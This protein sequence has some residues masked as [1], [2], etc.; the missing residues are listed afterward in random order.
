VTEQVQDIVYSLFRWDDGEIEFEGGDLPSRE[1]IVLRMSTGDLLL[2]G[3]RRIEGWSRIRQGVGP[4]EQRY[5]LSRDATPLLAGLSLQKHELALVAAF[6]GPAA[7]E[8]ICAALRQ[9]D[10][11]TCRALVGLWSVGVL[12]RVPQ[13]LDQPPPR[14]KTEPHAERSPGASIGREVELFN[15]L[16]CFLFDLVTFELRDR[17]SA[18]FLR[19]LTRAREDFPALFDGASI[20]SSG[21]VD[22]VQLRQNVVGHEIAGYLRGLD[23]LLV[24]EQDMARGALGERKAAIIA[25]G[26]LALKQQQL[27]RTSP[28][29]S[30]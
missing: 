15:E 24:I 7:V 23:H 21:R 4:L 10:Y 27:E 29:R 12:D 6:D 20:D 17:S 16:H 26:L 18:F 2:E 13:D 3:V 9:S 1:V 19:A 25:D 30:S 8:E 28:G 5:A 14:E 11:L 22:P